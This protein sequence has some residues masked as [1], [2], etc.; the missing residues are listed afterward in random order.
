MA[1]Y[2]SPTYGAPRGRYQ[3]TPRRIGRT[4]RRPVPLALT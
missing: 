3:F 2:G 1:G 4:A